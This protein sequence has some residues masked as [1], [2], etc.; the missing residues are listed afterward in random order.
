MFDWIQA[1]IQRDSNSLKLPHHGHQTVVFEG[2]LAIEWDFS[3]GPPLFFVLEDSSQ[4]DLPFALE[5]AVT[6]VHL[7][8]TGNPS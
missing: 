3:K 6:D 5:N 8:E 1:H 2:F 4:H 7:L